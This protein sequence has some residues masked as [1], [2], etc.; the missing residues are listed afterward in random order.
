MASDG[1]DKNKKNI[2]DTLRIYIP[3]L[4]GFLIAINNIKIVS[5][6]LEE[7][8]ISMVFIVPAV[9]VFVIISYVQVLYELTDIICLG[10][11]KRFLE[12]KINNLINDDVAIWE[13]E[14]GE[15]LKIIRGRGLIYITLTSVSVAMVWVLVL[16]VVLWTS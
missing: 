8:G 13:K 5:Q 16:N 14:F 7:M 6:A 1:I 3:T 10:V 4:F 11:Y 2:L 15:A 12:Q 9:G